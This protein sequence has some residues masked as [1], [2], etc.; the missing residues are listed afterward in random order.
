MGC[1]IVA[2]GTGGGFMLDMGSIPLG[3]PCN[4]SLHLVAFSCFSSSNSFYGPRYPRLAFCTIDLGF[5]SVSLKVEQK[6]E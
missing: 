5:W 6:L 2:A 4:I 1:R 3:P